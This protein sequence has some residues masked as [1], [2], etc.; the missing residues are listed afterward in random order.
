[1]GEN[2]YYYREGSFL[3]KLINRKKS[4]TDPA[5]FPHVL[6]LSFF[7]FII[8]NAVNAQG[9][10]FKDDLNFAGQYFGR[11][12]LTKLNKDLDTTDISVF[13]NVDSLFADQQSSLLP[14][15]MSFMERLLWGEDGLT[16]KTGL[17]DPLSPGEREYELGIRRVM[18]TSHQILGFTTLAL[19]LSADYFG[20]RVIDGNRRLGD[21]HQ[22]FVAATIVSYS[23]T[24]IL[25]ILS[26]P[27]LIRRDEESTTSIHKTLAWLHAAGMILT[28]ILGSMIGGRRHFNIDKAHYHQISGYIT[29]ALFASAMIVV[30]F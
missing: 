10:A 27:P 23:L 17:V 6:A 15:N 16:R 20:Q 2:M 30:T 12:A 18:L 3:L 7:L 22:G 25:A 13:G 14:Q 29:T 11:T 28:P 5:K 9:I 21:T 26:P 19:M 24:G 1:M 8:T 4:V